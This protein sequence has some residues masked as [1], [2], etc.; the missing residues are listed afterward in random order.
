MIFLVTGATSGLGR[1]AVEWLLKNGHEVLATG[2]NQKVGQDLEKLGAFFTHLDLITASDEDYQTL[3]EG[4]EIILH[5][6][7]LSSPW[8][9]YE[10]FYQAN[11]LVSS[12]LMHWAGKLKIKRFIYVSS[13]SIYFNFKSQLDIQESYL[14]KK[15]SNHYAFTKYQAE[16]E[17]QKNVSQ[18][19]ETIYLI[20]RPR[21]L[22]GP[23][24]RVILPRLL[25]EIKRRK[26]I[27]YLPKAGKAFIDLTFVLNVVYALFIASTNQNLISGE[28]FNITNQ[29]PSQLDK[30]LNRLLKDK[31]QIN[32]QIRSIQY[33]LLYGIASLLELTAFFTKKEPKLTRY[34]VGALYF[35]M[36]LNQEQA[37]QRLGYIPKYTLEEGITITANWLRE[38]EN[39]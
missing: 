22:F 1:N 8:G 7:A 3:L 24:D 28:V 37:R 14:P 36:T 10:D 35:D 29:Q 33:S 6:A 27:L 23:H 11:V 5:C 26:G 32:Y 4:C 31:L 16:Q 25:N 12:R 17:L 38:N 15:F 21:G 19:P 34:S 2:R 9:K 13:P 20:I 39:G 18:Y 30:L